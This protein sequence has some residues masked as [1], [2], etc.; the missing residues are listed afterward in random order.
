[1]SI[2]IIITVCTNKTI[3]E[4]ITSWSDDHES[5]DTKLY[6]VNNVSWFPMNYKSLSKPKRSIAF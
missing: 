4:A 6:T 3:L 1:M 2:H 5:L